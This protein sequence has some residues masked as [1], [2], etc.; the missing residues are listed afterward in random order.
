[1]KNEI[2]FEGCEI[3]DIVVDSNG[4]HVDV[5]LGT[6]LSLAHAV[7]AAAQTPRLRDCQYVPVTIT[8]T[9]KTICRRY[10]VENCYGEVKSKHHKPWSAYYQMHSGD[11]IYAWIEDKPRSV[12]IIEGNIPTDRLCL[13]TTVYVIN[14]VQYYACPSGSLFRREDRDYRG[15]MVGSIKSM[16]I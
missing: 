15:K 4:K 5:C 12:H 16:C 6:Y 13:S 1:M 14:E 3:H 8:A 11:T 9:P 10:T 2:E 7:T